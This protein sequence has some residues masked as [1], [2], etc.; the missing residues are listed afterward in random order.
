MA[1][2]S[3]VPV[4]V[5]AV[6]AAVLYGSPAAV[7]GPI[8]ALLFP[9]AASLMAAVPAVAL[10]A[11]IAMASAPRLA[12]GLTGW[13]RHLP[14]TGV[15]HRRALTAGLVVAQAPVLL[16][17]LAG[18]VASLDGR[19]STT[20]PRL[21][22]LVPMAWC[23]ALGGLRVARRARALAFG[24]GVAV[25]MGSWGW[26]ALAALLL[27]AADWQ[28]GPIRAMGRQ[29]LFKRRAA[30]SSSGRR[31]TATASSAARVWAVIGGRA[32][33]WRIIASWIPGPF[34]LLPA[35]LFLRNNRLA[36]A[37]EVGAIRLAGIAAGV[38]TM[39]VLA[40]GLVRRRPPWPWIRSLPWSAWA[41]VAFDG[42]GLAAVAL[43]VMLAAAA[44]APAALP[45]MLGTVPL[46]SLRAAAAVRD[47]VGRSV[48][49]A[50]PL[51]IEGLLVAG[52][53]ALVPWLAVVMLV[54]APAAAIHAI[55]RERHQPVSRW[56]ELHHLAAGDPLSW[57]SG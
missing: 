24:A 35:W 16:L 15:A 29:A 28:A 56:H 51:L 32:L 36:P 25:W 49:A 42:I 13:L 54:L 50:G 52:S 2:R 48:G 22:G 27:A 37:H 40:D 4:M 8:G 45:A 17:M 21:V 57:S 12:N 41:R 1:L 44:M 53:V 33:K 31:G 55:Q 43:P 5:G 34:V 14:A 20:L 46:L 11:A 18:G 39:A 3:L 30:D 10:S 6:A 23:S 19:L 38:V 26:M 7:L 47:G 9:P